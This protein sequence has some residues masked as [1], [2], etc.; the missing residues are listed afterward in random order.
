M[1]NT[2]KKFQ[3]M[4]KKSESYSGQKEFWVSRF[5]GNY[6]IYNGYMGIKVNQSVYNQF[7]SGEGFPLLRDGERATVNKKEG[8]KVTES[9]GDSAGKMF[10]NCFTHPDYVEARD[11]YLI[12]I[13]PQG[14]ELRII[15]A[16]KEL[17]Y[18]NRIYYDAIMAI[19]PYV[20]IKAGKSVNPVHINNAYCDAMICPIRVDEE[21]INA[22]LKKAL[23]EE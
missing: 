4:I 1:K 11:T 6:Y 7:F 18:I 20:A 10:E 16:E 22:K 3:G 15:K 13:N 23:T 5:E 12:N 14:T 9:E 17:I 19:D 2:F 8:V 21:G